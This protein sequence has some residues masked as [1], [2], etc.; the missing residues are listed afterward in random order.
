M[1]SLYQMLGQPMMQ[2]QTPTSFGQQMSSAPRFA[3]PVQRMSYIMQA[4]RN[5]AAFMKQVFPDIPDQIQNNPNMILDYLQRTRGITDQQIQ[6]TYD[7]Y[8]R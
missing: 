7:T 3:N 2:G 1:T 4:M 8:G 5:P 6:Q